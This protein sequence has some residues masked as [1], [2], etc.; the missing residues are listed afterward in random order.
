VAESNGLKYMGLMGY[1]GSFHSL[2]APER[3]RREKEALSS[4]VETK[5]LIEKN[6]IEVPIVSA[7]ATSTFRT[8]GTFPGVTE[9]QAGTYITMDTEYASIVGDFE[10]AISVLTTVVSRPTPTAVTTDAGM[11]KFSG[12]AGLPRLKDSP[13]LRVHELNEEHGRLVLA[14]L[15]RRVNVGDKLELLP[16]HGC[17]TFNLYDELYGMRDGKVEVVWDISGRGT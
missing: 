9:V 4:L 10:I 7:G 12:D 8:S 13:D 1:A 6:G 2:D 5:E 17:T 3:E 11:K 14:N 15:E 16:S